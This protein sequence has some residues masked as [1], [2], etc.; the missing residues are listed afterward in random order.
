MLMSNFPSLIPEAHEP[1][2]HPA[3]P[4]EIANDFSHF[5]EVFKSGPHF[6]PSKIQSPLHAAKSDSSSSA[7]KSGGSQAK[8]A[9]EDLH[10]LPPRFWRTSA[11]I[12]EEAEM[13]AIDVSSTRDQVRRTQPRD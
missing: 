2:P 9:V 4:K 13:E 8:D 11:M 10:D 6:D 1:H 12:I 3:A 5:Q 7:P